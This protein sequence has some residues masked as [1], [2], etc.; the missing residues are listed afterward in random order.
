MY[1]GSFEKM[2]KL[3]KISRIDYFSSIWYNCSRPRVQNSLRPYG[4]LVT[5]LGA[6]CIST[7][8][9]SGFFVLYTLEKPLSA[10]IARLR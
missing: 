8:A 7:V 2:G 9:P 1:R 4:V 10:L 3:Q 5:L 6:E